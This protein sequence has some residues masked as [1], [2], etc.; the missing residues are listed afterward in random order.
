MKEDK[1]TQTFQLKIVSSKQNPVACNW[2]MVT[3]ILLSL[4]TVAHLLRNAA[5]KAPVSHAYT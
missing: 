2:T 1:Y 3:S 4:P 5:P